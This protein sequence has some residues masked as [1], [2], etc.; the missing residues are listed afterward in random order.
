MPE[1][2]QEQVDA[3]IM[4]FLPDAVEGGHMFFNGIVLR[5]REHR[6]WDTDTHQANSLVHDSL[7]RLAKAG[8]VIVRTH[9]RSPLF[10][11]RI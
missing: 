5:F 10:Y 3:A 1:I 7:K 4:Q 11:A 9:P 6:D 8:R 2:T